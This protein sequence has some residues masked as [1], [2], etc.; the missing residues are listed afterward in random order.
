LALFLSR[1]LGYILCDNIKKICI[2]S[3]FI[4]GTIVLV[5]NVDFNTQMAFTATICLFFVLLDTT[6]ARY[7]YF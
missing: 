1:K 7:L 6:D 5:F 4:F 3:I 2:A